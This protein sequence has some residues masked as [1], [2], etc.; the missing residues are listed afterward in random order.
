MV[1]HLLRKGHFLGPRLRSLR[2]RHGLTLEDL[3]A[4]C[5]QM[6][7]AAAP[8]VSYLSMI[9]KSR[10]V[11]SERVLQLLAEVFQKDIGWF[12]DEQFESDEPPSRDTKG[13]IHGV[14]LE[15]EFLF[16]KDLLQTA[17]PELLSQSGTSGRQFAHLLIR[18]YQESRH[19][20][21]PDLERAAE[22]VGE[23]RLPLSAEDLVQICNAHGLRIRWFDKAPFPPPRNANGA[24]ILMRSFFEPP[25]TIFMNRELEQQPSRLK[26]DL[27]CYLGH[28]VLHAGD[29]MISA[30]TA[31]GHGI[32][33][34]E[35][36]AAASPWGID[37]RDVLFAW[38]D[39]ECSFFAGALLCPRLPFRQELNR[40]SYDIGV[41]DRLDLT[42]AVVMR[43]MTVVSPYPHWHF[44][45]AY[46]PGYLRA[47]YRG[48]GIPLPWGNMTRV[49]DPCPQWAVFS[50]LGRP[51]QQR[52][53]YTQISVLQDRERLLLYCCHSLRTVDSAGNPH[54][55]SVGVDLLPAAQSQGYDANALVEGIAESCRFGG[56]EATVAAAHADI[57]L[58]VAKVLN[59]SW[60]ADGLRAPARMICPRNTACPRPHP[61]DSR[62]PSVRDNGL[63]AMQREIVLASDAPNAAGVSR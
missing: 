28:R 62:R 1:N 43:R 26:Y 32:P 2:K 55:L 27:A 8:S 35:T 48:N 34:F 31:G 49:T 59:I 4:R 60:I 52:Q 40:C 25:H 58:K 30:R 45:D 20:Q 14:P 53:P 23:K 38:R 41:A 5:V 57:I 3:S 17:I 24:N 44:F 33:D 19:N 16:S 21:L 7:S 36:E 46:P 12:L 29:G 51:L 15:P 47:V 39:F 61:C 42:P 13:G 18:S 63:K 50:M 22:A 11:P 56:G 9:E 54:V 6:D 37:A 10:R